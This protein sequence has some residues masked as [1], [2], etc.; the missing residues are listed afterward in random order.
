[1][2]FYLF[3]GT[4]GTY[5]PN[6][7]FRTFISPDE[8]IVLPTFPDIGSIVDRPSDIN[9]DGNDCRHL[10]MKCSI[11]SFTPAMI[12]RGNWVTYTSSIPELSGYQMDGM[13]FQGAALGCSVSYEYT[14]Q[15]W[16][17]YS[18]YM[19]Y[20]SVSSDGSLST[21]MTI[22]TVY[23]TATGNTSVSFDYGVSPRKWEGNHYSG[24]TY[25]YRSDQEGT[26][27]TVVGELG[28]DV[29]SSLYESLLGERQLD[30]DSITP[31]TTEYKGKTL[32]IY[33]GFADQYYTVD[34]YADN[35]QRLSDLYESAKST[36]RSFWIRWVV[37]HDKTAPDRKYPDLGDLSVNAANGLRVQHVNVVSLIKDTLRTPYDVDGML[38][39]VKNVTDKKQLA[40]LYLSGKYGPRLT[41]ADFKA[42]YSNGQRK[43]QVLGDLY[44]VTQTTVSFWDIVDWDMSVKL[45]YNARL[46]GFD[47]IWL[48]G[49]IANLRFT[50]ADAWDL[51]PYS[52]V[53]DWFVD[54]GGYL[55]RK[56]QDKFYEKLD[57]FN[58]WLSSHLSSSLTFGDA[59]CS[60]QAD[61]DYYQRD[62][63]R[64][65]S[66]K[67][68]LQASSA[69]KDHIPELGALWV[70]R[71]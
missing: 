5:P 1:M 34:N 32:R 36:F 61:F 20:F 28:D 10:H 11:K 40:S 16:F 19:N 17:G 15:E 51:V 64:T 58:A 69:A 7:V 59:D 46:S 22:K 53:V 21:Y 4:A 54:V 49:D 55:E 65:K 13:K 68:R 43:T 67:T 71:A 57:T 62:G 31:E 26:S 25:L 52:F 37:D 41:Y 29:R 66:R 8:S 23:R 9:P 27:W 56:D 70:Q 44:C 6:D 3:P 47:Q 38:S 42:L 39:A 12:W 30:I 2:S 48:R 35:I 50:A 24:P 14:N 63:V 45:G 60:I 33:E 18:R